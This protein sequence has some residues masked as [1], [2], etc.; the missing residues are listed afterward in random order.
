MVVY[1]YV[2]MV[3]IDVVV[4]LVFVDDDYYDDDI[5]GGL[6]V[7]GRIHCKRESSS[8]SSSSSSLSSLST[9][10]RPCR[11]RHMK[12][13]VMVSSLSQFFV[14]SAVFVTEPC[15]YLLLHLCCHWAVLIFGCTQRRLYRIVKLFSLALFDIE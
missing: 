12:G 6:V 5:F 2:V 1:V 10:F 11:R 9:F 14:Y 15:Q 7:L 3:V 8:S 4:V 13:I